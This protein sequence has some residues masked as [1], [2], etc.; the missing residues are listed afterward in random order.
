MS[1]P[2]IKSLFETIRKL[3]DPEHGCPWDLKQTHQSL[4]KYLIE[5]CYEALY[6]IENEDASAL[7]DELGDVQLQILL[8]SIIGEE[9]NSF[10]LQNVFDNLEKKIIRRHPHVFNNKKPISIKEVKNNWKEIKKNENEKEFNQRKCLITK[11]QMTAPALLA[12]NNIGEFTNSKKFDWEST[13][14]VILKVEEELRELKDELKSLNDKNIQEELGDLLFTVAQ[15]CRHAGF[16][17]EETLKL[18]NKKFQDRYNNMIKLNDG[19]D[20][21]SLSLEEKETLWQRV[22][23]GKFDE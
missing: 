12:A 8:H 18:A 19:A 11:K 14:Q 20:I 16:C 10:S 4:K 22:K 23:T 9:E 2:N 5:E 15:V 3:R 13:N 6:A 1:S 21:V 7:L 17:P